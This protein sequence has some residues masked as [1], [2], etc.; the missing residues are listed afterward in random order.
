[1]SLTDHD[2]T[3]GGFYWNPIFNY[4][5]ND[6]TVKIGTILNITDTNIIKIRGKNFC[7]IA[8]CVIMH[9]ALLSNAY[10]EERRKDFL[11]NR[12]ELFF[13]ESQ[14]SVADARTMQEKL[15]MQ[16]ATTSSSVSL[17]TAKTSVADSTIHQNNLN[18][19]AAANNQNNVSKRANIPEI[20]QL[21]NDS[22]RQ[23]L[24]VTRNSFIL[25]TTINSLGLNNN[26][27]EF[28]TVKVMKEAKMASNHTALSVIDISGSISILFNDF[29]TH[30]FERNQVYSFA[31]YRLTPQ[32]D[33]YNQINANPL[34]VVYD[35]YV[36]W[37]IRRLYS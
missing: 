25:H 37:K 1:M 9:H 27:S 10:K 4:K 32:L 22:K 19:Q 36:K 8:S 23:R 34:V 6:E 26:N 21:N 31:N 30:H 35:A 20:N 17:Q 24:E 29:K 14:L 18:F 12:L 13:N 7:F 33:K 16:R 2:T 11:N 28:I 15:D 5:I 3:V